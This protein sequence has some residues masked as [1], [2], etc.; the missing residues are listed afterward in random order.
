MKIISGGQTGADR[1]GLDAA[2]KLGLDYGGYIPRGRM[3]ERGPLSFKYKRMTE[4]SSRGYRLRTI[5]NVL[6]ADATL[7]FCSGS[8]S[9]GTALTLR[10]ARAAEK[11]C[12]LVNFRNLDTKGA[13]QAI[14]TWIGELKPT[15]LNVAGPRES[16]SR[17]MHKKVLAVLLIALSP[18]Q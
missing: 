13:A 6:K 8:P 2:I 4:L 9:G 7:I 1:A 17:G 18:E 16:K 14:K 15:I 12:L 5:R 10:T 3:T 11:P